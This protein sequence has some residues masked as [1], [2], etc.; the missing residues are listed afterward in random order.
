MN[1]RAPPIKSIADFLLDLFQDKK[2]QLSTIDGYRL[3]I[4]D[5]LGSSHI[6]VSKDDNLTHLLDSLHGKGPKG[7]RGIPSWNFS[8]VLYQFTKASFESLKEASFKHLTFK[9]IFLFALGSSKRRCEIHTLPST[10]Q[11]A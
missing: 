2:L 8:L 7:L 3:A 11:V 1:F 9:T 6:I 10:R 4:A 5:E